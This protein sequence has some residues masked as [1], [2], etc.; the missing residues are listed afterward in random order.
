MKDE[1]SDLIRI[2]LHERESLGLSPNARWQVGQGVESTSKQIMGKIFNQI[3]KHRYF[4]TKWQIESWWD[5]N[6]LTL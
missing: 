1:R 5:L 3:L 6:P 2:V 4:V